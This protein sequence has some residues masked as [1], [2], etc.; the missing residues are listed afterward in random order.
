MFFLL[1]RHFSCLEVAHMLLTTQ[2]IAVFAI[3]D[4]HVDEGFL[5]RILPWMTVHKNS[6]AFLALPRS[7]S[8]VIPTFLN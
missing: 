7:K 5:L 6:V 2:S 8:P 4:L 3:F 1:I